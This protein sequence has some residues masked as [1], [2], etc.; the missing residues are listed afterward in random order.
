MNFSTGD[1]V[2]RLYCNHGHAD[3]FLEAVLELTD[4]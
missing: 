3:L 1:L 4:H 2:Y